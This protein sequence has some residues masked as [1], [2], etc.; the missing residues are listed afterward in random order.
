MDNV[1]NKLK[2]LKRSEDKKSW[3]VAY[4]EQGGGTLEEKTLYPFG[5]NDDRVWYYSAGYTQPSTMHLGDLSLAPKHLGPKLA[6][7]PA[8]YDA[9]NIEVVQNFC[10]SKDGTTVPYFMVKPKDLKVDGST[11]TLLYGY[12]GFEI[13]LTPRYS[14]TVGAAWL[15]RGGVY[16]EVCDERELGIE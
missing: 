9:S 1:K 15:E 3:V 7:L 16:V 10:L 4:E 11:P 8:M 2:F 6:A 14:G 12:G 13:S 5:Y